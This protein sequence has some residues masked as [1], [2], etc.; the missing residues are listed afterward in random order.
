MKKSMLT[1]TGSSSRVSDILADSVNETVVQFEFCDLLYVN[2]IMSKLF[3]VL[4][5]KKLVP[6]TEDV[7]LCKDQNTQRKLLGNEYIY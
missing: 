2:V 3:Q 6:L 7:Y 1:G 4:P 5:H